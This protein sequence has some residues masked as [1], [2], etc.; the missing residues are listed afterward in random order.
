MP[1]AVAIIKE[2]LFAQQKLVIPGSA[3]SG[4]SAA[5][6]EQVFRATLSSYMLGRYR[7]A[8]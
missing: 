6:S 4:I 1:L 5:I 8:R 2:S 7:V 3:A